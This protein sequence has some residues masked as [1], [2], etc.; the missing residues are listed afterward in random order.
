[1]VVYTGTHDNDT[2]VG[3]FKSDPGEGSTRNAKDIERER[4]FCL[5]YL[6]TDGAEIHWDFIRAALASV[7][8]IAI[9]PVQDILGLGTEARMNLPAS[10]SGNWSWRLEVGGLNDENGTDLQVLTLLYGR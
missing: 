9:V 3:W 4:Q 1:M 7:A 8:D 5:K 10:P 6:N 2:T